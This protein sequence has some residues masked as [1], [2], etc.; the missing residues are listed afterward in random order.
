MDTV[1]TPDVGGRVVGHEGEVDRCREL[2]ESCRNFL[3]NHVEDVSLTAE[4]IGRHD[5]DESISF[6][7]RS[8]EANRFRSIFFFIIITRST[9]R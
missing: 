2:V 4:A 9:G 3:A 6:E 5:E 8:V 1:G 7:F